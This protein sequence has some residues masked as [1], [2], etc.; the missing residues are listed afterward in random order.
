MEES[1]KRLKRARDRGAQGGAEVSGGLS[2][3][4]KIRIQICLDVEYFG[5]QMKTLSV[6][7]NA[8]ESFIGLLTMAQNAR[9]GKF[10]P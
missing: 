10:I 4:D 1:L 6:D 5:S 9:D 2:D 8:I 7:M 3:D